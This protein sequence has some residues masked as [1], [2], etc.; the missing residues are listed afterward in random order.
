MFFTR[1]IGKILRGEITPLQMWLACILGAA[2]GFVPAGMTGLGLL[3]FLLFLLLILNANLLVAGLVAG[4]CKLL[5]LIIYPVS[6]YTGVYLIQPGS[7]TI[8]PFKYLANAPVTAL[9]GFDFYLTT[10][11]LIIGLIVGA[12]IG[13]V[14]TT[15]VQGFR[16][17]MM[18]LQAGSE[19]YKQWSSKTWVKIASWILLG[20]GSKKTYEERLARK[21]LPIRI[22]G[23]VLVVICIGLLIGAYQFLTDDL[24]KAGLRGGLEWVN[25]A[26]VDVESAKL[27]LVDNSMTVN[28]LAVADPN[29]LDTNLYED[30]QLYVQLG[31]MEL[32]RKRAV[33]EKIKS[34]DAKHG[35]KRATPGERIGRWP[36]SPKVDWPEPDFEPSSIE[37]Y[38]E[39][40]QVWKDR[41]QQVQRWIEWMAG[42]GQAA[43]KQETYQE[44]LARQVREYGYA[45]VR[46]DHLVDQA[47][48]L[49]IRDIELLKIK[50]TQLPEG[51]ELTLHAK[52]LSTHPHLVKE[53]AYLEL[54]SSDDKLLARVDIDQQKRVILKGHYRG[55][56][57]SPLGEQMKFGGKQP[58]KGGT[59]DVEW[60]GPISTNPQVLLDNTLAITLHDTELDLTG[61]YDQKVKLDELAFGV[62]VYGPMD[63]PSLKV[64]MDKIMDGLKKAG[65]NLVI[66]KGKE[67]GKELIDKHTPDEAKEIIDKFK[68]LGR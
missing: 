35:S 54:R 25:G 26:T 31:G 23:V 22:P 64:D 4:F 28:G 9:M 57:A 3:I 2:I 59:V 49:L 12:V 65:F 36:E 17:K 20:S 48:T 27:D 29:A 38:F 52:N 39:Q 30:E 67:K 6:F 14:L 62:R 24:V 40:A 42:D 5:A 58:L 68:G 44:R 1:K 15:L 16:K 61:L 41:L 63:N 51:V 45:N 55:L 8:G 50:S 46:A 19:K 11:S 7:F 60:D 37:D 10:G 32:L 47:P 56:D 66:D 18:N 21:S 43:P 33:I 13:L 53:P 34:A